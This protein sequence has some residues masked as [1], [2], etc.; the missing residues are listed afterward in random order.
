MSQA[1]IPVSRVREWLKLLR[2]EHAVVRVS[3]HPGY[4]AAGCSR[5]IYREI[6][7]ACI[8]AERAALRSEI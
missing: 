5:D 1:S 3:V 7:Q 8:D 6:E 2:E 4:C